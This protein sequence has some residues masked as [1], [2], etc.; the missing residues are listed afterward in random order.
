[1]ECIDRHGDRHPASQMRAE[2]WLDA[3]TNSE[4]YRCLEG[5]HLHVMIGDVVDSD[6][7]MVG[8]Y[9]GAQELTCAPGQALRHYR[10]GS[11]KCAGAERV[12]DCTERR[13][14]RRFG[15]GDIFFSYNAK[16]CARVA[17]ESY[18]TAGSEVSVE[19]Q[20]SGGVGE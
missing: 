5:S 11:I 8:V 13:N 9:K 18:S 10:G 16:V 14:M 7:G 19:G 12:P 4:I 17:S 1:A 2:T 3:S 6:H 15:M 20:F